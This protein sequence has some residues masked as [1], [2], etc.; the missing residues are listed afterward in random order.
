MDFH[1]GWTSMSCENF[2]HDRQLKTN[3][4]NGLSGSPSVQGK[5]NLL[6]QEQYLG[7]SIDVMCI[8]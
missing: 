8:T 1:Q 5:A 4:L 6:N 7:R 3:G 2:L